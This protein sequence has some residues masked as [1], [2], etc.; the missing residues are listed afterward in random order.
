MSRMLRADYNKSWVSVTWD[1]SQTLEAVRRGNRTPAKPRARQGADFHFTRRPKESMGG[2][3]ND[4]VAVAS[5]SS[6]SDAARGWKLDSQTQPRHRATDDARSW[7][8]LESAFITAALFASLGFLYLSTI[9]WIFATPDFG[10]RWEGVRESVRWD[11]A[12][13]LDPF[14]NVL[15]FVPVGF[16][17]MGA[18]C[19]SSPR[20]RARVADGIRVSLG[21]LVLALA[22][23]TLQ[24]WI[25]LRDPS[26]RDVLALEVGAIAGCM[27]WLAAGEHVVG[28]LYPISE[29]FQSRREQRSRSKLKR[30]AVYGAFYLACV[31][32]V[33]FANP[34]QLFLAYR[35]V[36][37][38]LQH[39]PLS[40][41]ALGA[42]WPQAPAAVLTVAAGVALSLL[43]VCRFGPP[44]VR[45]WK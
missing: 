41:P 28:R 9:P 21:C 35:D 24:F 25:P 27:L 2:P 44:A 5:P 26:M 36:S 33:R 3:P 13:P 12:Q 37:T 1:G 43:G 11:P 19:T 34:I 17:W 8:R 10:S 38:S 20:R 23:E 40:R 29:S 14:A 18:W 45:A 42:P 22:A 7:R 16:L 31:A 32:I 4:P 39:I 30:L 15:A 6:V